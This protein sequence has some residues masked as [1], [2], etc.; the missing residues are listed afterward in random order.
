M[1]QWIKNPLLLKQGFKILHSLESDCK[2]DSEHPLR[3][4]VKHLQ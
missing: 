3:L 1:L 4:V 2:S